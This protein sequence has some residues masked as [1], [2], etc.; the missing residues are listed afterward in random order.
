MKTTQQAGDAG[1]RKART[2]GWLLM[3]KLGAIGALL[4]AAAAPCC[5]PLLAAA[6]AALGLSALQ[7]LR[8]YVEYTIQ[9]MVVLA[10]VGDLIAYRRHRH[11]GPLAVGLGA[12]AF[13]FFAYYSYYHVLL[14]YS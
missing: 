2:E 6:G 5:F 14:L 10:L 12:A 11:G 7:S 1:Q 13:L 4:A 9:T 8:G 3:D